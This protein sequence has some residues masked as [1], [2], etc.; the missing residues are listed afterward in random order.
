MFPQE[1]RQQDQGQKG[2]GF[3]PDAT[4]PD[5]ALQILDVAGQAVTLCTKARVQLF[6]RQPRQVA[7]GGVGIDA[8]T[9]VQFRETVVAELVDVVNDQTSRPWRNLIANLLQTGFSEKVG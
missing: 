6:L 7:F 2:K 5:V 4:R 3:P 9:P 1:R 8:E